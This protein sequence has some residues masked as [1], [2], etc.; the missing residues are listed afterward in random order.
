LVTREPALE[1]LAP[2]PLNLVNFRYVAPGLDAEA[3][4]ALNQRILV[5]LQAD[6]IAVPSATVIR[7]KFSIRVAIT[8]HRSRDEDFEL[9]VRET[10][11][12][13]EDAVP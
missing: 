4:N 13:G 10:V 1:L 11:R 6:G 8:N 7:G 2:V 3:L 12:I 5:R 9:L